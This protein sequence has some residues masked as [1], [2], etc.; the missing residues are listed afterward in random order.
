MPV[1][2]V[3]SSG[4]VGRTTLYE[5]RI[6]ERTRSKLKS[7]GESVGVSL[8]GH[9]GRPQKTTKQRI[10]VGKINVLVLDVQLPG[11]CREL[12]LD[13]TEDVASACSPW[14]VCPQARGLKRHQHGTQ[15]DL[16]PYIADGRILS[17][18]NVVPLK[19]VPARV[20]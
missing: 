12:T 11:K 3:P 14:V 16:R 5:E 1:E 10:R 4:V 19:K 8:I 2:P 18:Y 9:R 6:G 20:F 13:R 7:R 15:A 17:Q